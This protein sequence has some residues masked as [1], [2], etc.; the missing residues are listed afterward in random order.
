MI[1]PQLLQQPQL[2]YRAD[3]SHLCGREFATQVKQL[4][5]QLEQ[6]CHQHQIKQVLLYHPDSVQFSLWLLALLTANIDIVLPANGQ[7]QSI[8][9][10]SEQ[11]DAL[12]G[13]FENLAIKRDITQV[14]PH[15]I[16]PSAALF[17]NWQWP[18]KCCQSQLTFF[19]SG[20]QGAAKAINKAWWQLNLEV[21]TLAQTFS[22]NQASTVLS[23]VSHQHIYGLLFKLLWPLKAG[24][25]IVSTLFDYPEQLAQ[26]CAEH[27]EITLIA[28]PA[29]L[30]RLAQDDVLAHYAKNLEHVFSSGGPLS[31]TVAYQL[32]E[33]WHLPIT[34]V[35]GSTETGGIA[36][37]RLTERQSTAWQPFNGMSLSNVAGTQQMCLNSAYLPDKDI[38]L[39]DLGLVHQN[40]QFELLGRIDRTIKLEEKR[41]NLDAVERH[42]ASLAQ[43]SEVKIIVL[44]GARRCL[45][46]V[47]QLAANVQLPSSNVQKRELNQMIKSHLLLHFESVCLPRKFRYLTHMPYNSQG[48]LVLSQLE[49]LFE[50]A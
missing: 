3:N 27:H 5:A 33:N 42:I 14:I 24:A 23:T 46:C 4:S 49:K 6:Y 15:V 41:V 37:R 40:G 26:A 35:Y 32:A 30:S 17:T 38:L 21:D 36:Y 45:G 10:A 1:H 16:I 50:S 12:V 18:D 9:D 29:Y 8:K 2:F 43:V 19:T 48:K 20:S 39:D 7:P 11:C 22:L 13:H 44:Q 31:D 28:S 34:Q 25:T 47:I